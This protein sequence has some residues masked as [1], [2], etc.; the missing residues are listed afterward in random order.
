MACRDNATFTT[1]HLNNIFS[2]PATFFQKGPVWARWALRFVNLDF[3]WIQPTDY[4]TALLAATSD[5]NQSIFEADM[6]SQIWGTQFEV[7]QG[8]VVHGDFWCV[9]I[10]AFLMRF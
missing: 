7:R 4:D 5:T 2:R 1:L 6:V 9:F 8:R 10:F 3:L